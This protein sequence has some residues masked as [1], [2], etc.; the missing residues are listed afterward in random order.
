MFATTIV[1]GQKSSTT[2]ADVLILP[3]YSRGKVLAD[4]PAGFSR[5]LS[6]QLKKLDFKGAWGSAELLVA[7][8]GIRAKFVATVG[9]G[10][11]DQPL[12]K[13][14]E[15]WRRGLG[16]IIHDMR[17]HL[18]RTAAV[19]IADLSDSAAFGAAA[20]E[21]VGL[22]DYVFS[23]YTERLVKIAQ[24][25][26]L[27][28]LIL[29]VPPEAVGATQT[30]TRLARATLLGINR[31][32]DLVNRPASDMSPAALVAQAREIAQASDNISLK[33][34]NGTQ[35]RKQNF[36]A[37]LAVAQGSEAEPY[38][39][40]LVYK[41]KGPASRRIALVGKGVTFDSG[42]LSIKPA[43]YMEDMKMDMA[44][45]ATVLGV[46]SVLN[47]LQPAVEVHG[48]I[49]ACENMISGKAYRPG[50]VV[51]AK[52]GKTI[53]ILNTDAE[54]RVTL[55]DALS[56][57]VEQKPDA[58]I[59]LATLTGACMIALGETYA[60]LFGN[61]QAL[62]QQLLAAAK[63]SGEGLAR[64][65]MPEEY[66]QLIES[67]LADLKNV[68]SKDS[69]G[70][71]ITAALFLREFVDNIA[72]AHLDIAGPV[73]LS[74]PLIPYWTGGATGYGVRTLLTFLRQHHFG[75]KAQ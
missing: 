52:N 63:Q 49:A 26:S 6:A 46:F 19:A 36:H 32:R 62:S 51:R 11:K 15:G 60:G 67:K 56:Y 37:F 23:E 69:Y 41:P 31:V 57:A 61:N 39:I 33:I 54:G 42:G 65:P 17:R 45:A 2:V 25:R 27:K 7:P 68:A 73:Y 48:I 16:K 8:R 12:H 66:H 14:L 43:Q 34:M 47:K 74:R 29:M 50:D 5:E 58:I 40:H 13:Q 38:V 75:A 72:W 3:M 28:K 64:F 4:L 55:A 71:A 22:T 20:V 9:L 59:D 53:E 21:A 10:E 1:T 35:A 30:E 44:G 70:G 18:L 24:S